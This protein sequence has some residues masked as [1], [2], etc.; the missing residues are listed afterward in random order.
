MP[1]EPKPVA[2]KV[3]P[4]EIPAGHVDLGDGYR[5]SVFAAEFNENEPESFVGRTVN[6]RCKVTEFLGGD[7]NGLAYLADDKIVEDKK[8][9]VR[10]LTGDESNE[11][12][13][14]ILAE[15]C[16]SLSDLSHPNIA[17]LIDSGE[18]AGGTDFLISEYVDALSVGDIMSIHG[19]FN[20]LRAA[21]IIRQ[22]AS[23]LNEAHQEGILHRDL[24]PENLIIDASSGES[25]QTKL[26]N[27]G[28]SNGEPTERIERNCSAGL[29]CSRC[30][31]S[32]HLAGITS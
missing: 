25:E 16:V 4:Y 28:A 31:P 26:V 10:I 22:V 18:F 13:D 21:R 27:F 2:R 11:I 30:S 5:Q 8:V 32:W 20:E 7:E 15:E 23:A 6:G 29:E 17:R 3:N 12:I 24:R 9:M 14:S 19:R 1:S